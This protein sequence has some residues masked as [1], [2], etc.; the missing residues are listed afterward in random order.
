M[1]RG[2]MDARIMDLK[3]QLKD[4]KMRLRSAAKKGD[5]SRMAEQKAVIQAVAKR[6]EGLAALEAQP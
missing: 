4:A 2:K 6:L 3:T 5:G 1:V